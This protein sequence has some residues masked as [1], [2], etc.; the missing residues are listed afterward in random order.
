ML[1]ALPAAKRIDTDSQVM[2]QLVL[3]AASI[4]SSSNLLVESIY[5]LADKPD[6]QAELR[7][8]AEEVFAK[9]G[10]SKR[11]SI[12]KL[13]KMDSFMKEVQRLRGNISEYPRPSCLPAPML[14]SLHTVKNDD[15]A[16]SARPA[17]QPA[18]SAR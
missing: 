13:K 11:E 2:L 4:H 10:W 3:C 6:V 12:T 5:D 7:Q 18:S 8:E 15:R 14:P 9:G 1:E 16:D 17:K